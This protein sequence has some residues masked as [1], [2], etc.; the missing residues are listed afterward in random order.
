MPLKPETI[1]PI[2]TET[3]RVAR[4]VFPKS[5]LIMRFRDDFGLIFEDQA[6]TTLFPT[7]RQP[8]LAL[9]RLAL[10]ILFQFLENIT[11]RQAA[12]MVRTRLAHMLAP[13]QFA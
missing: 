10:I 11:D 6:F 5:C 3:A 12:Q 8:G 1:N 13:R 9:W 2:P 4:A 7:R